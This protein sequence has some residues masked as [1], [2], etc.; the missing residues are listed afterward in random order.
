M[1]I[2][3]A[4]SPTP[5]SE[6]SGSLFH[7]GVEVGRLHGKL[8]RITY[9]LDTLIR[10][11]QSQAPT[12]SRR[13]QPATIPKSRS[14]A[15][16]SR[17]P[18]WMRKVSLELLLWLAAKSG[19]WLLQYLLPATMIAWAALNGLGALLAKWIGSLAKFAVGG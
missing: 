10:I 17:I 1:S 3:H 19:M 2:E 14:T 5:S 11:L 8:D 7:I 13:I 4:K 16:P 12:P 15:T 9:L 18:K 6:N